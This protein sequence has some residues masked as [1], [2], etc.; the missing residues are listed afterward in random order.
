MFE[1]ANYRGVRSL[2]RLTGACM[3]GLLLAT[4]RSA[5]Q[6]PVRSQAIILH[7]PDDRSGPRAG[8]AYLIGGSVT[9]E[10]EGKKVSPLMTLFGWQIEHAFYAGPD[11]PT[12]VT[13]LILLAGGIEQNRPLPSA[14]WIVGLRQQ[15]GVEF[16]LGPT[17]TGAGTQFVFAAGIT[18]K[19]EELN[20][21]VNVAVAPGR[22][23]GSVSVTAGFNWRR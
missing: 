12:P 18:Q 10:R 11:L 14:S 1:N 6:S 23:G 4:G 9:A 21:P 7:E 19:F 22:R 5:A 16:G 20:V 2:A 15:N 17:I 13:E 8:V 3:T